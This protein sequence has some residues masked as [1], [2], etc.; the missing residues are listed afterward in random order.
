MYH[1]AT[2]HT[3]TTVCSGSNRQ[4]V[5]FV[6]IKLTLPTLQYEFR[7]H[8]AATE[9]AGCNKGIPN[10]TPCCVSND[11]NATDS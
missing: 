7:Q 5:L 3:V 10:N 2:D 4:A 9:T 1:S 8:K 11:L 6:T